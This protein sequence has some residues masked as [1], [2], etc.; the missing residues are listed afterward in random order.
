M[1]YSI[2]LQLATGITT[3]LVATAAL[4]AWIQS[5]PSPEQRT[6]RRN[7]EYF[8][9]HIYI[10]SGNSSLNFSSFNCLSGSDHSPS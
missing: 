3:I 5:R 9:S 8:S 6:F 2:M 1:R 4:F 7:S 10:H